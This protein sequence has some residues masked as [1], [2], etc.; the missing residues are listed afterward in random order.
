MCAAE[1][2]I[3]RT[4]PEPQ[5]V[6]SSAPWLPQWQGRW[7]RISQP[8]GSGHCVARA[9]AY[10]PHADL[11][12][13]ETAKPILSQAAGFAQRVHEK[14]PGKMLAYNLSPSFNWDAAGMSDKEIESFTG[15]LAAHGFVWQFITLAGFHSNGLM[16]HNFVQEY[17]KRGMGAYVEMIQREERR[18]ERRRVAALVDKLTEFILEADEDLAVLAVAR[19]AGAVGGGGTADGRRRRSVQRRFPDGV[20]AAGAVGRRLEAAE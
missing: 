2:I 17:A 13:M 4:W 3:A 7:I 6:R 16:T 8:S 15:D 19:A 12:W 9:N 5:I 20:G 14:H 18:T 10:A 11:I 1:S